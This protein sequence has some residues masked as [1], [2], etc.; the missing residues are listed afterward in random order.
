MRYPLDVY[1]HTLNIPML[2]TN[3]LNNKRSATEKKPF[4]F[5]NRMAVVTRSQTLDMNVSHKEHSIILLIQFFSCLS[6]NNRFSFSLS[7]CLSVHGD[8]LQIF[9]INRNIFFNFFIGLFSSSLSLSIS[10][11]LFFRFPKYKYWQTFYFNRVAF[12]CCCP[13]AIDVNGVWLKNT[14]LTFWYFLVRVY[15]LALVEF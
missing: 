7:L 5:F 8:T 4:E 13:V 14:K 11:F 10:S 12:C 1:F 15:R 6:S 9:S 2:Y 3:E